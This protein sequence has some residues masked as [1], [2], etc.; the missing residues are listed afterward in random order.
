MQ[1]SPLA[2]STLP[3]RKSRRAGRDRSFP[4]RARAHVTAM[5]TTGLD[6]QETSDPGAGLRPLSSVVAVVGACADGALAD[7]PEQ[8]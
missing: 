6:E 8:A 1:V 2:P 5:R 7:R 3:L 4:T